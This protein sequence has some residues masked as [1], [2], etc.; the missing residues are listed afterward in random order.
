[1][2]LLYS[3]AA[4]PVHTIALRLITFPRSAALD[5]GDLQAMFQTSTAREPEVEAQPQ[6]SCVRRVAG[7]DVWRGW[8][9]VAGGDVWR[10]VGSG[11]VW[12]RV[13]GDVW[14]RVAGDVW[15]RVGG[16]L[17]R[18]PLLSRWP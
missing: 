18:C 10:R 3:L 4:Q 8:R 13:A 2:C 6:V 9:R 14:R 7:G 15:R 17:S 11:D 1:M 12:R 16:G 5:F